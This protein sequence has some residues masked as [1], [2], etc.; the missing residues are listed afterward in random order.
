V[1]EIC[2]LLKLYERFMSFSLFT[3]KAVT[4]WCLVAASPLVVFA[5]TNL[6]PQGSEHA[7]AGILI[8]DQVHPC[9]AVNPAG[10][11]LVWQD[12][13][14]TTNGLRIRAERL[15]G[16]FTSADGSNFAASAVAF[17]KSKTTGDQE[18]PWVALQ[19]DGGAVIVWQGGK[20]GAQDIYAR[21][22]D[23]NGLFL[24]KDVL[25]NARA[26]GG[27]GGHHADPRVATLSGGNVV[28][29]WSSFGQDGSLQGVFARLFTPTGSPLSAEFQVNQ[30]YLNNQRNPAVA[31][32]S[33]GGFVVVW[34]SE[35]QRSSASVDVYGRVFNSAGGAATGEF[36][37]NDLT[38]S[39]CANPT[40][41]ESPQ[42][43]FAVAWS[44]R[45]IVVRGTVSISFDPVGNY[46]PVVLD[47][48]GS[49]SVA[50]VEKSTNSWD[51]FACI[52]QAN[53]AP[54][55]SPFRVNSYTVGDQFGPRL[56]TS[57]D[58]YLVVWTSLSQPDPVSGVID[59]R[60]GVFAQ[61]F[62]GSGGLV[63]TNDVHV[64]TT[65]V[66]RQIQPVAAANGAGRCLVVWSSL[67]SDANSPGY[68]G[69]D[70]FAQQ[71]LPSGG[72]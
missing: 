66:K 72:Q 9:V 46:D 30:T 33:G 63:V 65:T 37:I 50:P 6:N 64:N 29:V 14:V 4:C 39:F 20:I 2:C 21:F 71:Y 13:A 16:N 68:G 25:V 15:N 47:P 28:V 45:D 23:A 12:N 55:V 53:G 48:F 32:L 44:Q 31:P 62:T 1:F 42:G 17:K 18:K 27:K 52:M 43:G 60:E 22:V 36:P 40:V 54:A 59:P 7:I 67:V 35:L 19:P 51:V 11:F 49:T 26:R 56:C 41:S 3:R 38:N 24:T 69:F 57:G 70:L 5:Q 61:M 58:R 34:I 10:G 8:G